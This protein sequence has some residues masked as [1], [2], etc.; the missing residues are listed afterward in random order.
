M[1]TPPDSPRFPEKNLLNLGDFRAMASKPEHPITLPK[2]KVTRETLGQMFSLYAYLRPYRGRLAVG[3]SCSSAPA[4][5]GSSFRFWP[6]LSS[7]ARRIEQAFRIACLMAAILLVQA[8]MSYFQSLLFN[9]V[10]EFG[11]SDL[12][13]ALFGH[14]TEMP[15]TFFSQQQ[16]G[17]L[18]SRMFADLTQLQ[19]A[20]VMAIPQFLRQ[21]IIM[22]GSMVMMV[23]ISPRL[24]GVMLSASRRPSSARS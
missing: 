5:W 16:V 2:V 11:L 20:F 8:I 1:A 15:M 12:R 4:S 23:Y 7:T 22:L 17:E 3:C 24:T 13:K 10:G 9:T 18:T 6:V 21:S 14:L 19:D